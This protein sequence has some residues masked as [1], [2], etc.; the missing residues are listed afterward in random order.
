MK[1]VLQSIRFASIA[2]VLL[3]SFTTAQA[4]NG[5]G[6]FINNEEMNTTQLSEI[7]QYTG[8]LLAGHYFLDHYGNF[9]VVGYSP[10]FNM[11]DMIRY[12][13]AL[14]DGNFPPA[15]SDPNPYMRESKF[16]MAQSNLMLQMSEKKYGKAPYT[17]P[18]QS[19]SYNGSGDYYERTR[20][21]TS[22]KEGNTSFYYGNPVWGNQT[23]VTTDGETTILRNRNGD[24][25]WPPSAADF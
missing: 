6:V 5:T 8:V 16:M 23:G 10:A 18:S 19:G 14:I 17:P 22:G 13:M 25:I 20:S 12:K 2:F 9:G 1:N 3:L 11:R 7:Q 24:I 15:F 4:Q 21:Y